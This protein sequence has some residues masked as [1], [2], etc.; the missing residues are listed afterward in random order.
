[1]AKN[2]KSKILASM[3][4]VSTMAVFYAAPVMAANVSIDSSNLST[5]WQVSP[6][7]TQQV[8]FRGGSIDLD[9]ADL[10]AALKNQ[11]IQLGADG[12]LQVASGN[13][14]IGD[15]YIG[16][17]ADTLTLDTAA[18]N[19]ITLSFSDLQGIVRQDNVTADNKGITE[20]EGTLVVNGQ[21]EVISTFGGELT[22]DGNGNLRTVN[23][24]VSS[25]QNKNYSLNNIGQNTEGI[26]RKDVVDGKG[27][28]EIENT[29]VV[30]GKTGVIST[31]GGQFTLDANG[32]V[33]TVGDISTSN[34]SL[35]TV[36][37]NTSGI[38]SHSD[39]KVTTIEGAFSVN[40]NGYI[41]NAN[42]SFQVTRD[43][44][45]TASSYNGVTLAIDGNQVL[46][47]DIDVNDLYGRTKGID[48]LGSNG[49]GTTSIEGVLHVD[50]V[51]ETVAIDGQLRV[52]D[53][54]TTIN[55]DG[56]EKYSLN[57]IGEQ[58]GDI[59]G[60]VA[61]I[62]RNN[63]N[64]AYGE[65]STTIEKTVSVDKWGLKVLNE[66]G[67][68]V[69]S[70]NSTN[71]GI[72]AANGKFHVYSEGQIE[73]TA[74]SLM[75]NGAQNVYIDNSGTAR[76]GAVDGN[77]VRVE[78][79]VL[80]VNRNSGQV[81]ALSENGLTLT[82]SND[83]RAT[84]DAEQIA[85]L[86][87]VVQ[88]DGNVVGNTVKTTSGADLDVVN[89]RTQN[90]TATEDSTIFD[91]KVT[92]NGT[93][94]ITNGHGNYRFDDGLLDFNID[95]GK[96]TF[97]MNSEHT[98]MNVGG[99]TL[100]LDNSGLTT[101]GA[102]KA[103]NGNF[104]VDTDGNITAGTYNGVKIG[105]NEDGD[106]ILGD[107]TVID[108]NFNSDNVAGIT[109]KPLDDSA[110][111]SGNTTFIEQNTAISA[112]G[113]VVTDPESL[114]ST[115]TKYDGFYVKDKDGN[116]VSSLT[117][118]KLNLAGENLAYKDSEGNIN[119][120]ADT[121]TAGD[122]AGEN[123]RVKADGIYVKDGGTIVSSLKDDGLMLTDQESGESHTLNATD[124]ADIK[125]IDRSGNDIDGYTTTIE[126]ATSFTKDGMVT[127]NITTNSF[128]AGV[129]EDSIYHINAKGEM[130]FRSGDNYIGMNRDGIGLMSGTESVT[131]N[132][133]G[134]T[135]TSGSGDSATSTFIKGGTI[136]TDTLNVENIV[137]GNSMTDED[138]NSIALGADGTLKVNNENYSLNLD[139]TGFNLSNASNTSSFSLGEYGFTFSGPVNLGAGDKV[140]FNH[141]GSG[142]YITLDGLVDRVEDLEQKTQG[143][144]FDETTGSTTIA[145]KVGTDGVESNN[146]MTVG[147]NGTTFENG[148]DSK[149]NINGGAID[150]DS[151]SIGNDVSG[152]SGS[153]SS[154]MTGDGTYTDGSEHSGHFADGDNSYKFTN[155]A[156]GFT[157][158]VTDG[159]N[160]TTIK[161]G[162]MGSNTTVTGDGNTSASSGVGIGNDG[163]FISDSV[164]NG[165]ISHTVNGGSITDTV[166]NGDM[167]VTE[168]KDENG[169][170]TTVK[171]AN[172]SS[173]V[174]QDTNGQTVS[175]GTGTSVNTGNDFSVTDNETGKSIYMSDIGHVEDIDSEI[176]NSDGSKTTVVDAVNNEAE[177]RRNEIERVDGRINNLE[178]RVGELE[179][180]IDK[181][182]A[183]AAAIANLRT[184]GYDPAAPTEVAV[185]IG[186]YRDETGAA[187]GLF[188]YPNRDF[189]LSL[190]VS[191]S[192]DE[193]MGGIGATWKFGRKSPEKVAEIKKAQA[194]AD[195]RRA[196]EAKLAKAE[197]MKQAAKEA[198]IKA[199]QERHAKLAAERAAQAEAAK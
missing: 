74:L 6:G 188:H 138:G 16:A 139:E 198:K 9:S 75:N 118:D 40:E 66:N 150:A 10:A 2:K 98:S 169:S 79:G 131:I 11:T 199:Q 17:T 195:A 152:G 179:D 97:T 45:I 194:E 90:M 187:L 38:T 8:Q 51:S 32:N 93:A 186:Q 27:M 140:G 147:N 53:D 58:V 190:S 177:I 184:M 149:T 68:T 168:V 158:T 70:V 125:G 20:I 180:R 42:G 95:N 107:G 89:N 105:M 24:V 61:G 59:D 56:T 86:N 69:A 54:V 64:L 15:V 55:A 106:I 96:N 81:A 104:D 73:G 48:R 153:G 135:F 43:G 123:V 171:D 78:D 99:N 63:G 142:K 165:D 117:K 183:M 178:N 3:L 31:Y 181:V 14:L 173:T 80:T 156:N 133:D 37:N 175:T 7:N 120:T 19:P 36:G 34:Y 52:A 88:E 83:I 67:E 196:E 1:M 85:N 72:N 4:A 161:N 102:F 162:A 167:T 29:L 46:V 77:N 49:A 33:K 76:F 115:K 144:S 22:I 26:V 13:F 5:T 25:Y 119:V 82:S 159:K 28:T 114:V 136:T 103:A 143:I 137:L 111:G 164:T 192:G 41:Y 100:V 148:T 62:K 94:N 108:D 101:S 47:G 30:N 39:G 155:D 130:L 154:G 112:D 193:V 127:S 60:N 84:L 12:H 197:E 57:K 191:T 121:Y 65:G 92:V 132:G 134:T 44:A 166:T 50:K 151:S 23:D 124:I 129:T 189:M 113:I 176:Q 87:S 116:N 21:S 91:G 170:A 71:G 157:G 109:R 18:G 122:V 141:T 185:G 172:G 110:P 145:D 182:G 174:S 160:T 163:A 126:G 146:S 35:N 128:T